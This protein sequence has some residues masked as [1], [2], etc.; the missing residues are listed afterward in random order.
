MQSGSRLGDR[1]PL[2]QVV[3]YVLSPLCHIVIREDTV[4][5][6]E[7]HNA[8]YEDHDAQLVATTLLQGDWFTLDNHRIYDELKNLIVKGPGWS[9]IKG[10][11]RNKDYRIAVLALKRQC[12]G[13]PAAQSRK[14]AAYAR[15]ASAKY[16][17]GQ[18]RGFTF[19]N[20][21]EL[22]L[23]AHSTLAGLDKPVPEMKKV[24]D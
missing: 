7:T 18:K 5:T 12:E 17:N 24:T 10:F 8:V 4:V 1:V 11:D 3:I 14:A 2:M 23:S 20:Y 15:F 22:H 21:F 13:T 19:D 16:Y 9:C 6:P